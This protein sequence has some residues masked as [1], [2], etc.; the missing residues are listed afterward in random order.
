MGPIVNYQMFVHAK[1]WYELNRN[2]SILI[3]LPLKSVFEDHLYQMES[4]GYLTLIA[5]I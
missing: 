1:I 5:S 3:I 2:G 4:L